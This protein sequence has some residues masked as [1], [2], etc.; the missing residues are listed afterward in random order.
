M[1]TKVISFQKHKRMSV[2][3][4][5]SEQHN[6]FNYIS[7]PAAIKNDLIEVKEISEAGSVNNL[8]VFN[9]SD[10]F[11]FFMDGD[12]LVGAKQNRVLNTSVL[13]A[14]NSKVN[15]PVSCVQQGRWDRTHSWFK[16][17]DYIAPQKL[18]ADKAQEV[19]FSLKSIGVV[20]ADQGQVWENV[21]EYATLFCIKSPTQDLNEVYDQKKSDVDSFI[22]S[23]K[24]N[25][26]ANG[27]AIFVDQNILSTDVF[28]RTDIYSEYFTK[29]LRSAAIEVSHLEEKENKI[30]EAEAS[31]KTLT[32]FD[33]L[34]SLEYSKHKGVGV[35]EENRFET[36]KLTGFDLNY[37]EHSIH[38]TALNIEKDKEGNLG[39]H[40]RNRVY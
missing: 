5:L 36:E 31:Y 9:L 23:F 28:N 39:T 2:V 14:P 21:E 26:D 24:L 7:G 34:Q 17:S 3:Q 27:L 20:K 12:M 32:L 8:L 37:K 1:Q 22:S 4:L 13:L 19:N 18:R 38:L 35:G 11:V 29:I 10:K 30:T 15:L 40:K 16:E 25:T 6:T 33:S